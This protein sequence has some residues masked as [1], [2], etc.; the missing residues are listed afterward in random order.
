MATAAKSFVRV[1][2]RTSL[3]P[4][5]SSTTSLIARQTFRQS[6]RG[7]SSE[8]PKSGNTG[9]YIGLGAVALA[10]AGGYYFYSNP[11]ATKEDIV[12]QVFKPKYEDYQKVYSH[13]A[14]RLEEKDDYDDGSYGPV[15][16]RLAWHCSG[17]WVVFIGS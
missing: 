12:P 10:G 3:R 17:T 5:A 1:A 9:V 2:T 7:Y 8:A 16:V 4:A 14:E 6:R 15:L 11:A 13:I